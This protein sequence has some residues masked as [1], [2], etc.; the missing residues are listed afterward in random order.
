M[1]AALCLLLLPGCAYKVEL[2]STPVGATVQLPANRGIVQTPVVTQLRW[3][4]FSRQVVTVRAPGYAPLEVD[5]RDNE[6]KLARYFSDFFFRPATTFG[7]PRGVV[8]FQLVPEH[9]PSG[10]WTPDD[11]R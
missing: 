9:G 3:A 7:A 1:R 10:T 11:V 8:R 2:R 6:I 4:P 5:L